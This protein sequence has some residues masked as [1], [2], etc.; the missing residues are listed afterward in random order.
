MAG[1]RLPINATAV[2]KAILSGQPDNEMLAIIGAVNFVRFTANTLC[3]KEKLLEYINKVR[4][5]GYAEDFEE[6]EI[7]LTCVAAPIFNHTGKA[8]AAISVSGPTTRM[9]EETRRT[10]GGELVV[11]TQQISRKLGYNPG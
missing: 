5:S 4:E 8:L 6:L 3:N 10:V 9:N 1:S 7:G 11:I 2:G